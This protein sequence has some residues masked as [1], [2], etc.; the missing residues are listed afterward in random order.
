MQLGV[1]NELAAADGPLGVGVAVAVGALLV[2][3]ALPHPVEPVEPGA[4]PRWG[5]AR[6]RPRPHRKAGSIVGVSHHRH[7]VH[8]TQVLAELQDAS[9][10]PDKH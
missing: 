9:P 1:I 4:P 6:R 7:P 5:P 2:A 10:R 8:H 3:Y